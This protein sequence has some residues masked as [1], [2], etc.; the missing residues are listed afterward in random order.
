MKGRNLSGEAK[1]SWRI[2]FS[3]VEKKIITSHGNKKTCCEGKANKCCRKRCLM[4]LKSLIEGL[5]QRFPKE[6]DPLRSYHRKTAFLH[7]LSIRFDDSM[8]ALQQLP[9]CF[10]LLLGALEA[11]TRAGVL[12]HFFAPNYNLFSGTVFPRKAMSFLLHALEGRPAPAEASRSR[13]TT[14]QLC[15]R[16]I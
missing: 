6:L 13:L 14:L 5:K 7:M 8:W 10:L 2:S 9:A 11:H 1:E 3:H 16:D 12:P 4:L 15:E